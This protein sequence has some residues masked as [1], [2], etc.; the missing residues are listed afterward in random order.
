MAEH[1]WSVL[2]QKA[3]IDKDTNEVSLSGVVETIN[4]LETEEKVRSELSERATPADGPPL[5]LF[6][7][8]LVS[9]WTRSESATPETGVGRIGIEVPSGETLKWTET[10]FTL[11]AGFGWRLRVRMGGLPFMGQ[12]LYRFLVQ[13]KDEDQEGGWR[14]VA[15]IPVVLAFQSAET[16]VPG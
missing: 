1:V 3:S 7:M 4:V 15:R 6:P 13:I 2:C 11:E 12:G 8:E 5:L 9:Y 10:P 14:T 16:S